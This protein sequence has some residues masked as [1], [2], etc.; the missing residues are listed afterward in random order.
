VTAAE[1]WCA[2]T[3]D[4]VTCAGDGDVNREPRGSPT[5]ENKRP[6]LLRGAPAADDGSQSDAAS[7]AA[8]KSRIAGARHH[9]LSICARAG[10]KR[11]A[12]SSSRTTALLRSLC[13]RAPDLGA[14]A[15]DPRAPR[16]EGRP[17]PRRLPL[18]R[19]AAT[20][21]ARPSASSTQPPQVDA[22]R[23]PCDRDRALR[24]RRCSPPVVPSCSAPHPLRRRGRLQPSRPVLS[25]SCWWLS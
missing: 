7:P 25:W 22:T 16:Q 9:D 19:I 12:R 24:E 17:A 3:P 11:S 1:V 6:Q 8:A 10:S 15:T 4:P 2:V 18:R 14:A 20:A 23:W 21:R 5:H 13:F